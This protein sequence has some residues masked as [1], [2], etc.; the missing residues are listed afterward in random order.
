MSDICEI[1][2]HRWVAEAE[3]A[4]QS[5]FRE[6]VHTILLA[7]AGHDK[8]RINMVMKGG[9]LMAIRHN[10][11]RYTKDVD[12]STSKNPKELN[13]DLLV[14]WLQDALVHSAQEL[15]YELDCRVQGYKLKPE[16]LDNPTFPALS[17]R[18]GYAYRGT[19]KHK[20]LEAGQ[21]STVV[22]IDHSYN[23]VI[24]NLERIDF[25]SGETLEI[26]RLEDLIAEKYRALLQ[27]PIKGKRRRQDVYDLNLLLERCNPISDREK[28]SIMESLLAKCHGR[29]VDPC[30]ESIDDP[31]VIKLARSDYHTLEDE[32]DGLP[33]FDECY[34][35]L[36]SMYKE[37]PWS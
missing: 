8:L 4:S 30:R 21:C 35:R 11:S 37:L 31:M 14:S 7:V 13:P 22:E 20:R 3:E 24:P 28:F 32:V 29:G 6:A 15:D 26:Y 27:Q 23:E 25:S 2:L 18:V 34:A 33:S 9:L 17:I 1:D 36:T 16:H 19:P 12:F 5:E 10:S